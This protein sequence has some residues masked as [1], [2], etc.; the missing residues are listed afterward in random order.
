MQTRTG[1]TS[2][3]RGAPPKPGPTSPG[4]GCSP[5]RRGQARALT[6]AAA[7]PGRRGWTVAAALA[8][9]SRRRVRWRARWRARRRA[10]PTPA[11][12]AVLH[13][14]FVLLLLRGVL[15]LRL[16]FGH[17]LVNA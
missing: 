15:V 4:T 14:V 16:R 3:G 9:R 12:T 5:S 1:S 8:V 7:G 11:L 13:E 17:C 10:T 2:V 6:R